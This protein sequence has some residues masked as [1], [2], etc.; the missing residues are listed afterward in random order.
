MQCRVADCFDVQPLLREISQVIDHLAPCVPLQHLMPLVEAMRGRHGGEASAQAVA[1]LE[2]AL[3]QQVTLSNV[4]EMSGL[5]LSQELPA[6]KVGKSI[7]FIVTGGYTSAGLS[8]ANRL[9]I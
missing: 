2:S 3:S 6:L 5:A 9:F 8:K 1:R 7:F 4:E